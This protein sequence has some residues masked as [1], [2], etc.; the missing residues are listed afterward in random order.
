[1]MCPYCKVGN[2]MDTCVCTKLNSNCMFMYRCTF[3]HRWLPIPEMDNCVLMRESMEEKKMKP[4][5]NK[6]R[7]ESKGMLYVEYGDNVIKVP[8]PFGNDIPAGVELVE[9]NN[10]YYVKGYEPK[11]EKKE[12]P[13]KKN[14]KK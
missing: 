13:A 10:E 4:N 7:F 14:K 8:N 3:E 9:V 5:E 11:V 1:M 12:K 6:V 2:W